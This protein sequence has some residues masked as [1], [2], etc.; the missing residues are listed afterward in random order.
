MVTKR[1][2]PMI[3]PGG[4]LTPPHLIIN[5]QIKPGDYFIRINFLRETKSPASIR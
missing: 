2:S 4:V 5:V 3:R 1:E